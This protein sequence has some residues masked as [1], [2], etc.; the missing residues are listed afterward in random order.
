MALLPHLQSGWYDTNCTGCY[1]SEKEARMWNMCYYTMHTAVIHSCCCL[2]TKSCLTLCNPM[3]C[4]LPG[5]FT[6]KNMRMGCHFLLQEIFPTQGLN[7]ALSPSLA[8]KFFTTNLL[9][10][11]IIHGLPWWLSGKESA[12]NIGD[13]GL[14]LG[15]GRFPWRRKL[16]P[17]PVFLTREFQGQRNLVGYSPWVFKELDMT[18]WLTYK[19]YIIVKWLDLVNMHYKYF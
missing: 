17:T 9:S 13:L 5:N 11:P 18:E 1:C 10:Y 4:S 14:I 19:T 8:G 16:Q 2:V 7:M 6:G 15:L 3:D 12:C